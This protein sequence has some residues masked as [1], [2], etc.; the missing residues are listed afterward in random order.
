MEVMRATAAILAAMILAACS[1]T[2]GLDATE[3][4]SGFDGARVVNIAPHGAACTEL[5]CISIGSEWNSK[6]PQSAIVVASIASH[7]F[8][9][10]R[11][12]EF[13]I[14]GRMTAYQAAP[15]LS[16]FTAQTPPIR[17]S[18]HA[19]VVPMADLRAIVDARRVWVRVSSVRGWVEQPIIDGDRDSKALHALR[20]FLAQV[21]AGPK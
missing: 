2:T 16:E 5:P 4:R 14:D 1:S 15:G 10:L 17:Q 21:D 13:N 11:A 3:S 9:G 7:E 8:T 19:F 20:R 12:L 18:S 6:R